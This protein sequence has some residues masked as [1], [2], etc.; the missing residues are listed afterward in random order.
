MKLT[1]FLSIEYPISKTE[2]S[3]IL[4]NVLQDDWDFTIYQ[5][6]QKYLKHSMYV[7]TATTYL[8]DLF[9]LFN[10]YNKIEFSNIFTSY[11]SREVDFLWNEFFKNKNLKELSKIL[12]K[13]ITHKNISLLG[14]YVSDDL[15][16]INQ[17]VDNNYLP[18]VIDKFINVFENEIKKYIP[19]EECLN[20]S[21]KYMTNKILFELVYNGEYDFDTIVLGCC[22]EFRPTKTLNNYSLEEII[23]N[24]Y[25][26][27]LFNENFKNLSL[28]YLVK[29]LLT[30]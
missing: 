18:I 21:D 1:D 28:K 14:N 12:T 25:D 9:N 23:A 7:E 20:C 2:V 26:D 22:E 6:F 3:N 5:K 15:V 4:T 19:D 8:V 11:T 10:F 13:R 27:G 24:A 29:I 16:L 17:F 30:N